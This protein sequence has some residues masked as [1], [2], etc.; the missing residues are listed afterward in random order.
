MLHTGFWFHSPSE[1]IS[2]DIIAMFSTKKITKCIQIAF[3]V[4]FLSYRCDEIFNCI[5]TEFRK[6]NQK[7]L[8]WWLFFANDERLNF[9]L[10]LKFFLWLKL[11]QSLRK[12]RNQPK[13]TQ[14]RHENGSKMTGPTFGQS[15]DFDFTKRVIRFWFFLH[16]IKMIYKTTYLV[17]SK[18]LFSH[19]NLFRIKVSKTLSDIFISND[20]IESRRI[21]F[22]TIQKKFSTKIYGLC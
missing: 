17:S 15:F 4:L 6:T 19:K 18:N 22:L 10:V 14:K 16:Y 3:S 20:G 8:F 21:E 11:F 13:M 12:L 2:G 5:F 1:F 9:K 7:S